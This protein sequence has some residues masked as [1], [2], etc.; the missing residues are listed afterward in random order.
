MS[1]NETEATA[2][3]QVSAE[4]PVQ[5]PSV[6]DRV[7][8]MPLISS[9]CHMVSAAYMSTKESHP[10]VKTVCDAAEKGV[11][12]LTAVAVSGAQPILS[13]LEPQ[14]TSASE[15]AHKGLDKLEENLPI[16]Q[17]PPEKVLADTKELV[18][19]KVSG[20][21]EAV[22]NTV[23]S[24]KDTMASRVTEAVDVTRGAV[25]S[26]VDMTKSMVTSG[27]HSVMGS[28]VGQMV[29]SGVDTVLGKSEEWVDNHLPM[30]DAELA[31]LATSLEGFDIASV[32]QQ[33]QE[34]SYFVRLGSLSERLRQRAY[35]HS[36]GKL[37]STKQRA[38]EALL[39]L[40]QTLSLM[41]TVKQGVDQKLVEGQEKLHQMWLS[42]NQK[43]LQGP[44]E[45]AAKPEQVESQ[46]L[47]M[48][49]DIA[50]QLQTTCA[51]LGSSLQGLPA[52]VRDQAL[53]ARRQVEDLQ[54]TFS[55]I[56]SFKDL[57][58]S[59][60]TQSRGQVARAR[61]AL[62][63]MVEYVAQSTPITWLVGPFAPG[64]TEKAPEEKK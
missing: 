61:E 23:S 33:R 31:R 64:I 30:T 7:A 24:A 16:L 46:T 54:A 38:Q 19:S 29:L 60:L 52:H 48:F 51:S 18:S 49:R 63:H 40:S 1:T 55:G 37:Q 13:K 62:D 4:E 53:Q 43:Q 36:L 41:E 27:V 5:Q 25:Q 57:S 42:W 17:Q 9:T 34:Q 11:K 47:T 45:D 50:Q 22:S 3:P 20:A 59:I 58:G 8:G 26:G 44:E 10:H 6:V 14:L 21:R 32:A 39:Q 56:H 28:R 15:Y 2:S 35:E 12:T